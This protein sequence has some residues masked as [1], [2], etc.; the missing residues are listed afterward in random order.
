MLGLAAGGKSLQKWSA[1]RTAA[2]VHQENSSEIGPRWQRN[3]GRLREMIRVSASLLFV[4]LLATGCSTPQ[5]ARFSEQERADLIVRYYSDDT[6]Y[7]LKPLM[8]EA[9]FL[10]ILDRDA[11][12][13][14]AKQQPGRQLAVVIL[15][16]YNVESQAEAVKHNWK[17]LLTQVG[18]QRVV[19]LR[20]ANGMRVNGLPVLASDG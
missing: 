12:L 6:S 3:C 15:I 17:N 1:A 5:T 2:A 11:V 16:H 10:S 8:T 9:A 18:Y 14:V 20:S 7:L 4:L 13:K 19:F